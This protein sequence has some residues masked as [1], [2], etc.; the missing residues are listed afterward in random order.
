MDAVVGKSSPCRPG[1]DCSAPSGP[2]K[3]FNE[4]YPTRRATKRG[5]E[6]SVPSAGYTLSLHFVPTIRRLRFVPHFVDSVLQCQHL[7]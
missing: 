1:A 7:Y 5:D 3:P 4:A 6:V 2:T